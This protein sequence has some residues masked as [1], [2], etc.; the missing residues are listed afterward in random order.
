[1]TFLPYADARGMS[2]GSSSCHAAPGNLSVHRVQCL[3]AAAVTL[4]TTSLATRQ[5][6]ERTAHAQEASTVE[7]AGILLSIVWLPVLGCALLELPHLQCE[8]E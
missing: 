4:S 5:R 1:M 8:H 6:L 3:E 7:Y 2:V